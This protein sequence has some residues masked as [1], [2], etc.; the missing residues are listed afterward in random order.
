MGADKEEAMGGRKPTNNSLD[1]SDLFEGV[2]EFAAEEEGPFFEPV[3]VAEGIDKLLSGVERTIGGRGRGTPYPQGG[4][5]EHRTR[6]GVSLVAHVYHHRSQIGVLHG[7]RYATN[8]LGVADLAAVTV[9]DRIGDAAR[10]GLR[11]GGRAG[12]QAR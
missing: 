2:V 1:Q 5:A 10:A 4:R 3:L 6:T 12:H 7:C 8:D 11:G 9:D